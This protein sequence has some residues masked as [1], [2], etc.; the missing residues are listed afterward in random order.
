M[1]IEIERK[2]L[3]RDADVVSGTEGQL[4]RQG[5]LAA[6]PVTVRVR[7]TESG[8]TAAATLTVKSPMENTRRSEFEYAIPT[9]DAEEMLA[10]CVGPPVQKHRY[11]LAFAGHTWEIDI[12]SGANAPL[13]LAEVELS[14]VDEPVEL[15]AWVGTEVTDDIRYQNAYLAEHP[16]NTWG[17]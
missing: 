1:G 4:I 13:M 14:E 3:L 17:P 15:P 9:H 11:R 10:L 16:F 2:F 6:G 5:Y 7:V 12:F 8:T